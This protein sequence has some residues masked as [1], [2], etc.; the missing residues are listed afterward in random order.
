[1]T[2]EHP[3]VVR[4][5]GTNAEEG[6]QML[7]EAAPPN[8]HVEATMLDAA[9]ARR[10]AGG[11]TDV[12]SGAR[13][14]LPRERRRTAR[15]R[16]STC[17]SSGPRARET[18]LDVATGGG[19]VARRLREAGLEVVTVDPAPGMQPT[20]SAAPRISRS[21]T[22]SFDVVVC[23]GRARTTSTTSRAARARDGARQR[24]TS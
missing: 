16:I 12:W 19:H 24:A 11:M 10:G 7:A 17:S 18:A 4:L 2:I 9:R 6:R 14:G 22:A 8:L 21:P 5:D 15:A 23:R 1:M 20:S 3:I 13:R